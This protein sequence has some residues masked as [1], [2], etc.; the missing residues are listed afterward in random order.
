MGEDAIRA[1]LVAAGLG[2]ALVAIFMFVYYWG[3]G[4]V[5]DVALFLDIALLPAALVLV[6][7]LNFSPIYILLVVMIIGFSLTYYKEKRA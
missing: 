7:F 5:A 4:L 6:A 2:F 1:G 3:A